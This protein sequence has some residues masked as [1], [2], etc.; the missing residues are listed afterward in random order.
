MA[1]EVLLINPR[2]RKRRRKH[3][4]KRRR[5]TARRHKVVSRRRRSSV[6]VVGRKVNPRRRRRVHALRRHR[7]RRRNPRLFSMGGITSALIPAAIGGAGAVA[8]DVGLSFV[9]LPA[10]LQ[11]KLAKTG[12]K[13]AGALALGWVGGKVLGTDKGKAVT[14]GA[15]TVVLYGVIKDAIATVAPGVPLSGVGGG[16]VDY[17]DN[18]IGAYMIPPL[19]YVNPAPFVQDGVGAYMADGM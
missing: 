16:G 14:L 3:V 9:P 4:A 7:A 10:M 18:T 19:G 11:G 12:V 2:S 8:L 1:A 5:H 6:V 17:A 13:I 15:L